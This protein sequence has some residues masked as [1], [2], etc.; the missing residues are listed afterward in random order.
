M[1]T[2]VTEANPALA[3][4]LEANTFVQDASVLHYNAKFSWI[5]ASGIKSVTV[6]VVTATGTMKYLVKKT[7]TYSLDGASNVIVNGTV[8][9]PVDYVGGLKIFVNLIYKDGTSTDISD[10]LT[11]LPYSAPQ[12]PS[13]SVRRANA[14]GVAADDKYAIIVAESTIGTL[15]GM[16]TAAYRLKYRKVGESAW[17]T[18][19]LAT[20]GYTYSATN[21]L[22]KSGST[23]VEFA[24]DSSY[25]FQFE[26]ADL[27]GTATADAAFSTVF[28]LIDT[29][30]DVTGIA[31]GKAA[32]TPG[33]LDVN[34]PARFRQPLSFDNTTAARG[35]LGFGGL[36]FPIYVDARLPIE[37]YC[38]LPVD[39]SQGIYD[40]AVFTPT[41]INSNAYNYAYRVNQAGFYMLAAELR[42]ETSGS[43]S[44]TN[45]HTTVTAYVISS[46]SSLP[47]TSV[48]TVVG[49][50]S[51]RKLCT[52]QPSSPYRIFSTYSA[53]C[54]T[55]S[56]TGIIS[57]VCYIPAGYYVVFLAYFRYS[58]K[59]ICMGN[60]GIALLR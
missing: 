26:A 56:T 40:S 4:R 27:L 32:E 43:D 55:K 19:T 30:S 22:V 50:V 31:F 35:A 34:L 38:Q 37:T 18:L 23:L 13:F 41:L 24:G 29:T 7:E 10:M 45:A 44:N 2:T 14:S 54:T 6:E 15:N 46:L 3:G 9:V 12:I 39:L 1:A 5:Y 42:A 36:S 57:N 49:G 8:D 17:K 28:A 60:V 58:R 20:S 59:D 53:G 21:V 33:L 47:T 25:E 48:S 11:V 51:A 52:G 16:N